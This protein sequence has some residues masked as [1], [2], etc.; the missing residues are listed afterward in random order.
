MATRVPAVCGVSMSGLFAAPVLAD[1][2][3]SV[4]VVERDE[5]AVGVHQPPGV[6]H[7]RH[8]HMLLSSGLRALENLFPG[9]TAELEANGAPVLD[10]RDL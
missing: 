3:D 5:L 7:G 2:F 6:P 4:I 10:T 8:L 1:V 9:L